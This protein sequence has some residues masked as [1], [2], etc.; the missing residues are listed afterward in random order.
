M[1]GQWS[2]VLAASHPLHAP[3]HF[4]SVTSGNLAKAWIASSEYGPVTLS[5]WKNGCTRS[6]ENWTAVGSGSWECAAGSR[7]NNSEL[8]S[9]HPPRNSVTSGA[10]LSQ[11]S[12]VLFRVA[13]AAAAAAVSIC[14]RRR[15][16]DAGT[17]VGAR[18]SRLR[19]PHGSS[20]RYS[21]FFR[22]AW[23][24]RPRHAPGANAD[25]GGAAAQ[26]K[27]WSAAWGRI[28]TPF[29]ILRVNMQPRK[30]PKSLARSCLT[31][32]HQA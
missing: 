16:P 29:H 30:S 23:H 7:A 27:S 14:A 20:N 28:P 17:A 19:P 1:L 6:H 9:N 18:S 11:R 25:D 8:L 26:G 21:W 10:V 32:R 5:S 12:R 22:N 31:A 2:L 4:S 24:G 13:A 3:C 15:W